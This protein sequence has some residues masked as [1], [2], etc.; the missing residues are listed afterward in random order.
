MHTYSYSYVHTNMKNMERCIHKVVNM[1][2]IGRGVM[3]SDV[4]WQEWE[5]IPNINFAS[6]AIAFNC[7]P[8]F[9]K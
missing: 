8:L 3:G 6:P 9:I 4:N 7:P 1:S 2:N 5:K